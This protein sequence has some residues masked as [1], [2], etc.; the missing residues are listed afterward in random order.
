[1]APGELPPQAKSP[2]RSWP[3]LGYINGPIIE[4]IQGQGIEA[5]VALSAEAY[6][7]RPYDLRGEEKRREN[8][9]HYKGPGVGG[10]G[11]KAAK[12]GGS[13]PLFAP[14]SQCLSMNFLRESGAQGACLE[15]R[16]LSD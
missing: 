4:Q 13:P 12:S 6:E 14:P 3:S 16:R 1:M 11:T 2:K 7:R 9:R 10:D 15:G 8:P 5:Y